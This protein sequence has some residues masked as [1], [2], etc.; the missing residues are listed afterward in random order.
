[1]LASWFR[2]LGLIALSSWLATGCSGDSPKIKVGGTCVL[3]SDCDQ[4]LVC[5][6]SKCHDA[7]HTSVDC[8][9]GQS[10]VTTTTGPVC[11]LP[12]EADCRTA[13]CNSGFLCASDL[14][15][16]TGCLSATDCT[17]GQVCVSS[18]CADPTDLD[19]NGRLP[20]K[21]SNDAG[22]DASGPDAYANGAGRD[23]ALAPM[24]GPTESPPS[25]APPTTDTTPAKADTGGGATSS[26]VPLV[27]AGGSTGTGGALATGGVAGNGGATGTNGG[28]TGS[29][30]PL[31][32]GGGTTGTGGTLA[33]GGVANNGG[34]IGT[35]GNTGAGG[36]TGTGGNTSTG[37]TTGTGGAPS[38]G[39]QT[40]FDAAASIDG[41]GGCASGPGGYCWNTFAH[42]NAFVEWVGSPVSA[43]VHAFAQ[44]AADGNAGIMA[45]LNTGTPV[46][47]SQYDQLWFDATVPP[48]QRFGVAIGRQST[49]EQCIW[50]IAGA[51]E[52]RYTVDLRSAKLC[53]P[54]SCGL[55]R[56]QI[57]SVAFSTA[58][59]T[60]NYTLDINL[61][62]L[63]F[64]TTTSGFGPTTLGNSAS[65]GLNGWCWSLFSWSSNP[66]AI[67]NSTANWVAPPSSNQVEVQIAD[68]DTNGDTGCTVQIPDGQ[69]DLTRAT[70]LEFDA[71]VVLGSATQF[72]I[73][74]NDVNRAFCNYTVNV[75]PGLHTYHIPLSSTSYC[76][77]GQGQPFNPAKVYSIDF[78]SP[79]NLATSGDITITRLVIQ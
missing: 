65:L 31:A 69:T 33:I 56:S 6:M 32:S 59:W 55:D 28:T 53:W 38:T 4:P 29:D 14:R 11:Q 17:G 13:P 36:A 20:Q 77:N 21:A 9:T 46:D 61:T 45:L 22:T 43:A 48:G 35:G 15:C 10:C 44:S 8:P 40:A 63:G 51:G 2:V 76:G 18:V 30:V 52:T 41:S 7:C 70:Y 58:E 1:M 60:T 64:A 16:H 34:S 49:G 27:G 12:A 3:N 5:T 78:A 47:L 79:W 67:I 50:E 23:L 19:V 26:D 54:H 72:S 24:D 74:L 75:S 68:G 73:G 62:N 42:S 39:G 66:A 25:D 71:N 57:E 37:G